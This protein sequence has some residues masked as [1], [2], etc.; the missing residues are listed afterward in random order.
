MERWNAC[1]NYI[2]RRDIGITNF[3]NSVRMWGNKSGMR[4]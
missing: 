1:K 3:S 2:T 4:A